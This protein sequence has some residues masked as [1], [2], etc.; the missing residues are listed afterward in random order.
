M[1]H[2]ISFCSVLF[3]IG[4]SLNAQQHLIPSVDE[5]SNSDVMLKDWSGHEANIFKKKAYGLKDSIF[6]DYNYK[7]LL[8]SLMDAEGPKNI[9]SQ[10]RALEMPNV[11]PLGNYPM[12]VYPIDATNSYAA[13]I[14]K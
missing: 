14:Y 10:K 13:R 4:N 11:K 9:S 2:F 1:K 8:G 6:F 5:N 12:T 3:F 7:D